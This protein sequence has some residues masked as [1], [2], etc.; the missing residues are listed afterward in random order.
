LSRSGDDAS[1]AKNLRKNGATE[2]EVEF[3]L[4]RRVELN[5]LPSDRFVAYVERK[6]IEA[7]AHKVVPSKTMLAQTYRA[8][9]HTD[10]AKA[11][12]EQAI[13]EA[14]KTRVAVPADLQQRV[15]AYLKANP[16]C[17]WDEAVTKIVRGEE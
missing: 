6:L 7:G 10:L 11:G 1:R 9:V 3:L 4:E 15:A 14:A 8:I 16:E 13:A 2:A 12:I 5:A 17:P